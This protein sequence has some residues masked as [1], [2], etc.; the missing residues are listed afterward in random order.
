VANVEFSSLQMLAYQASIERPSCNDYSPSSLSRRQG[1]C[2]GLPDA[3]EPAPS[4]PNARIAQALA[5]PRPYPPGRQQGSRA[6]QSCASSEHTR[7]TPETTPD[8]SFARRRIHMKTDTRLSPRLAPNSPGPSAPA[9]ATLNRPMSLSPRRTNCSRAAS[10]RATPAFPRGLG[11]AQISRVTPRSVW[12]RHAAR[13]PSSKV[14]PNG[15][16]ISQSRRET[17]RAR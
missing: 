1:V 17:D 12:R 10:R 3:V 7:S 16:E 4:F 9:E 14:A 11:T 5:V 8:T 6:V 13:R 2:H 15:S